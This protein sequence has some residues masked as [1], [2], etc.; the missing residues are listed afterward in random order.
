MYSFTHARVPYAVAVLVHSNVTLVAKQHLI[1]ILHVAIPTHIAEDLHVFPRL[2]VIIVL[3]LQALLP[4]ASQLLLLELD[5]ILVVLLLHPHLLGLLFLVRQHPGF[6]HGFLRQAVE[7]VE[8]QSVDLV[9]TGDQVLLA[10]DQLEEDQGLLVCAAVQ[11]TARIA[12][13]LI[14]DGCC[15]CCRR[16]C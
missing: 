13:Q 15:C 14:I 12:R 10:A 3:L 8:G 11:K 6:L 5:S 16:F 2:V 9:D 4:Q 7:D 1:T